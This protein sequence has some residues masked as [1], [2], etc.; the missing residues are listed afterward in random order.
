MAFMKPVS[1][2]I[3]T[4]FWIICGFTGRCQ[5]PALSTDGMIDHELPDF[6]LKDLD[7]RTVSLAG[8]KGKV[9]V[10]DFWA[11]WCVP[12]VKSFP[13][14]QLVVDKY[15]SDS[16]VRILFIDT[17]EKAADYSQL[18]R[19]FIADHHYPF[20][21]LLDEKT[22]EGKQDRFFKQF[23]EPYIPARFIVD[24]KGKISGE[25]VGLPTNLTDEQMA[26]DLER[27]I[28]AARSRG[29]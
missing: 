17:R 10:L 18:V 3:L 12:C 24:P 14:M 22:P 19:Q 9:I 2:C 27:E 1:T 16:N 11:T 15:K 26:K 7:G 23:D 29:K 25:E 20:T 21:V 6:S 28:E 4:F 13:A 8:L 5:A